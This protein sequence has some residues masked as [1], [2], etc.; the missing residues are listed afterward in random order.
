MVKYSYQ[1][2]A[3]KKFSYSKW[4]HIFCEWLIKYFAW[5]NYLG[6]STGGNY[7]GSNYLEGNYPG[8]T[9]R[10]G[11]AIIHTPN[12]R[13]QFFWGSLS[14]GQL[15]GSQLYCGVLV[16]EVIVRWAIIWVAIVLGANV[17]ESFSLY[18]LFFHDIKIYFHSIKTN[19]YSINCI[20]IMSPFFM[21]SKYIFIQPK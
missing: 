9:I 13:G 2:N 11:R 5:K 1:I 16:G 3:W 10:G 17:L 20:F 8:V 21:I 4:K 15:F 14:G 6:H 19:L 18:H 7:L 12:V